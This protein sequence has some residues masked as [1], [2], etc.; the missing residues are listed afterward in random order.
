VADAAT[1]LG[2]I[3]WPPRREPHE[4]EVGDEMQQRSI[5]NTWV[6]EGEEEEDADDGE[7]LPSP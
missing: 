7:E 1:I 2:R 3:G 5:A 6:I 4:E